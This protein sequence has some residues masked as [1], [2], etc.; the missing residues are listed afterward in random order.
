MFTRQWGMLVWLL[1]MLSTY[2]HADE[3]RV[4]FAQK[5]A[6]FVL[7]QGG[8]LEVDIVRAALEQRGH[9]LVPIYFK[10]ANLKNALR[11]G[12]VDAISNIKD[13]SI[14]QSGLPLFL[15]EYYVFFKNYVITKSNSSCDVTTPQSL[16]QCTVAAWT[17]ARHH[18]K[19]QWRAYFDD[20]KVQLNKNYYEFN[21]PSAQIKWLI[22]GRV[23]ALLIDKHIFKFEYKNNYRIKG[24]TPLTFK[25][26]NLFEHD[27]HISLGFTQETLRNDFNEGLKALKSSPAYGAIFTHYLGQD[28]EPHPKADTDG[29]HVNHKHTHS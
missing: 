6:P 28:A 17:D 19:G 14:K 21:N 22:Q 29:K 12:R 13:N 3:V 18:L 26:Y 2:A 4:G 27:N 7:Q 1:L 9:T 15:S 23:D 25:H 11:M 10:D 16:T 20:P 8:G 5:R 24:K